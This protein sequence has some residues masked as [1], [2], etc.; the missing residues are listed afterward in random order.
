MPQCKTAFKR[1][2][3]LPKKLLRPLPCQKSGRGNLDLKQQPQARSN[4]YAV[5][6]KNRFSCLAQVKD[7]NVKNEEESLKRQHPA[8]VKD[9]K[10]HTQP[11]FSKLV[12]QSPVCQSITNDNSDNITTQELPQFHMPNQDSHL[13]YLE[14][15]LGPIDAKNKTQILALYDTGSSNSIILQQALQKLPNYDKFVISNEKTIIRTANNDSVTVLGVAL[16]PFCFK[17]DRGHMVQ[18]EWP[19]MI[20]NGLSE[21]LYLGYDFFESPLVH[22]LTKKHLLLKSS[23]KHKIHRI[24]IHRRA[25]VKVHQL[26]A[27]DDFTLLPH[28]VNMV[29]VTSLTSIPINKDFIAMESNIEETENKADSLYEILPSVQISNDFDTYKVPIINNSNQPIQVESQ[30]PICSAFQSIPTVYQIQRANTW[31]AVEPCQQHQEPIPL[32]KNSKLRLNQLKSSPYSNHLEKDLNTIFDKCNKDD[33]NYLQ[34]PAQINFKDFDHVDANAELHIKSPQNLR[35]KE[36]FSPEIT[37]KAKEQVNQTIDS[38]P[39]LT[40]EEKEERKTFFARNGYVPKSVQ[41]II[42]EQ[43]FFSE[44]YEENYKKRTLDELIEAID[45]RHLKKEEQ[46]QV[47]DLFRRHHDVLARHT[48]DVP[49]TDKITANVELKTPL[50]NCMTCR[51]LPIPYAMQPRVDRLIRLLAHHG[52]I[53]RRKTPSKLVSSIICIKKPDNSIR[54]CLDL[55]LANLLTKKIPTATC[56]IRDLHQKFEG[57]KIGTVLDLSQAYWAI[58]LSESCQEIFTFT[59]SQ[60]VQY[61]M[62]RLPMGSKQSAVWLE[63][64]LN[65]VLTNNTPDDENDDKNK[66]KIENTKIDAFSYCDDICLKSRHDSIQDHLKELECLLIKLKDAKLKLKPEKIKVATDTFN[67][68]GFHIMR[69]HISI[70]SLKARALMD[71]KRPTTIKKLKGFLMSASFYRSLLPRFSEI[72]FPLTERT[73]K[74]HQTFRWD[75]EAE[76][77]FIALKNLIANSITITPARSDLPMWVECDASKNTCAATCYQITEDGQRRYI[78]AAS[79]TF[80][81]QETSAGIF[82]KETYAVLFALSSFDYYLRFAEVIHMQIDARSIL[83]LRSCK[84]SDYQLIRFSLAISKYEIDIFHVDSNSNYLTDGLSRQEVSAENEDRSQTMTEKEAEELFKMVALPRDFTI[85]KE[86]VK[87]YLTTKE[88]LPSPSPKKLKKKTTKNVIRSENLL[89]QRIKERTPKLPNFK[90]TN[91][92]TMNQQFFR[93]N[94]MSL[95]SGKTTNSSQTN[96]NR[97]ENK[98]TEQQEEKQENLQSKEEKALVE[99]KIDQ[100]KENLE[101]RKETITEAPYENDKELRLLEEFENNLTKRNPP[102]QIIKNFVLNAKIISAG[103]ISL[104]VFQ[105]AQQEDPFCADILSRKLQQSFELRDGLLIHINQKGFE[106]LILP[107]SLFDLF[108]NDAHYSIAGGHAV[109]RK[110]RQKLQ[111]YWHPLLLARLISTANSCILCRQGKKEGGRQMKFGKFQHD[112]APRQSV[113]FD[114]ADGFP[115]D[116]SKQ[117]KYVYVFLEPFSMYCLLIKAKSK[118]AQEIKEA[119]ALYCSIMGFPERILSDNESGVYSTLVKTFCEENDIEMIST[120][121]NSSFQN[122]ICERTVGLLKFALK[123]YSRQFGKGWSDLLPWVNNSLNMRKLENT[124]GLT[125]ELILF[126]KQVEKNQLIKEEKT[127]FNTTKEYVDYISTFIDNLHKKRAET[128]DKMNEKHRAYI[129]KHKIESTFK[130]N[131][132]VFMRDYTI[133]TGRGQAIRQSYLGPYVIQKILGNNQ[134]LIENF[135]DNSRRVAHFTHLKHLKDGRFLVGHRRNPAA[136]KLLKNKNYI[137][138]YDLRKRP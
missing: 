110:M 64:L 98:K 40:Q 126:G 54:L 22:S 82:K 114:I 10:P 71:Y 58:G 19:C 93:T 97:E 125:P 128:R 3:L 130:V 45:V 113:H 135:H 13:P 124:G 112:R 5:P 92:E 50:E 49:R 133:A 15:H 132:V 103:I 7:H 67:M 37:E 136:E 12:Q 25:N 28:T 120:A 118:E 70:P 81:K 52:I 55:R 44:M 108:V 63:A 119:L 26:V 65:Q 91:E 47:R 68:V 42:S 9:P 30:F 69:N 76:K 11:I 36:G 27:T 72:A 14:V 95:R 90:I 66:G 85:T 131:D 106:Q 56:H 75:D 57:M 102:L 39:T 83:F 123:I 84:S 62:C 100:N 33:E 94:Q 104:E 16:I 96:N 137:Q 87:K 138:P 35:N 86:Q 129:N 89:P 1:R 21:S 6:V 109:A 18:I 78:G 107:E 32:P 122:G 117:W 41:D 17:N 48:Y 51:Y 2:V 127:N 24:P 4:Q 34:P 74:A 61:S 31:Q 29:E 59:D 105:Q 23:N 46:Q 111:L 79:R 80:T 121:P 60:R 99:K 43:N 134:C 38:D 115:P 20:V 53:A 101:T 77:A 116:T 73:R 88:D 8:Q